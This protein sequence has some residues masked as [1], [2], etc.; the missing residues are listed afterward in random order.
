MANGR[1]RSN[2]KLMKITEP[3]RGERAGEEKRAEK[4]GRRDASTRNT[5]GAAPGGR[6]SV[7][8]GAAEE[9]ENLQGERVW[10]LEPTLGADELLLTA[11][12]RS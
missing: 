12:K 2:K 6:E 10:C 7:E 11:P 4:R 5:E 1:I 8:R 9:E 3:K